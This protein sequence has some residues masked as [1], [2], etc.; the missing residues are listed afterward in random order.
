[1]PS[2]SYARGDF[3]EDSDIDLSIIKDRGEPSRMRQRMV[4]D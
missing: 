2:G 4:D 3:R 1:M